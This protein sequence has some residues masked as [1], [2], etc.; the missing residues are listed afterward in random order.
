VSVLKLFRLSIFASLFFISFSGHSQSLKNDFTIIPAP[1]SIVKQSGTY[2]INDSTGISLDIGVKPEDLILFNRYLQELAGVTLI[3]KSTKDS[4]TSIQLKLDSFLVSRK[5]G[6]H[7]L[8]NKKGITISGHDNAGVFYGVQTLLQLM[9]K[10][11][12]GVIS[13]PYCSIDD[14]PRFSYRG[15]HLDVSRHMFPVSSIKKWIDIL[16]LYKIN[17]FHWHL[18]DDQGWRIEIKKYPELQTISSMRKETIIG[19]KRRDPHLFDGK[20]YGGF[21]TQEEVAEIIKYA[22]ERQIE[23]IPEIELPGHAQAALAAYPMLGCTGGP[24]QAATYWGVFDDVYCAGKEQTFKFLENVLDEVSTLFPS[25]YIHIGG[26]E[27]PKAQWKVCPDCQ[28]RIK[29][30]HLKNEQELQSYFVRRIEKYLQRK[31]K[32]IIGWDEI[33]EGG[34][35]PSATVMSWRGLE[36]GIAAAKMHHD[37]IMTPEKYVYLDYYQSLYDGEPIAAGGY[38]PLAKVYGYEPVPEE[39]NAKEARY[40]KGVQANVWS[41]YLESPEKAEYQMFPRMIALAEIAWTKKESRNYPDFLGRLRAQD[42]LLN[43]LQVNRFKNFD[44]INAQVLVK[45]RKPQLTLKSSLPNAVIH[46]TLNEKTPDQT[47]PIYKK[48]LSIAKSSTIKA[49]IFKN[50]TMQ[51]RLFNQRFILNK[52]TGKD[53]TLKNQP[54]GNFIPADSMALLNGVEGSLL[55]ND[56]AWTGFSG[57]DLE[58]VIDLGS[59]VTISTVG[60][61]ILK[62]HWQKMWEPDQVRFEVSSDGINYK[63]VYRQTT[64]AE[65]GINKVSGKIAPVAARYIKVSA[66]NKGTIPEGAYGAGGKAWLMV[67]EIYVN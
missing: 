43:W 25:P 30:E 22:S 50:G 3:S 33:L 15:M 32:K 46:Y 55:Y 34:L 64:F 36:G 48:P 38:T 19:H 31:N 61:N 7:L 52:S 1:V 57:E 17:T 16:A 65:E 13:V 10:S 67:D 63:E 40:I 51:K 18:T 62:Y 2:T 29:D 8:I 39:L 14:Y 6:Y 60:M 37:V 21:Y 56:D 11:K 20:S 54:S 59:Q 12:D 23:I 35:A 28:K 9:K 45:G 26:D 49:A 27:C 24:Y 41:E 4:E 5:E 58:A 42:G 66:I 47:S 53:L 44:E